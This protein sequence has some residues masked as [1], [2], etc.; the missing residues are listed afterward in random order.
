V[1]RLTISEREK[2][3]LEPGASE[4]R[5]LHL[6]SSGG[7]LGA[8][9][10]VLELA[11][12]SSTFGYEGIVGALKNMEDPTPEFITVAESRGLKTKIFECA[13]SFDIRAALNIKKFINNH[14]VKILHCHGYKEDVFGLVT[15]AGRISKI[16]TNHLWKT[17]TLKAKCYCLMDALIIRSYDRIVGVSDEIVQGMNNVGIR[18]AFKI[19]NGIDCARFN[20]KPV[21]AAFVK[22][23]NLQTSDF[24]L[25]MISSLSYEKNHQAVFKA[26]SGMDKPNLK[27]LIV[28]SGYLDKD[29]RKQ[30]E[31]MGLSERV[32]FT[33]TLSNVTDVLSV[34]KVFLLPSLSEGL[35]MALL[36]AMASGK[37]VVASNV[38]EVG[39]V[40]EHHV[41]GLLVERNNI[42]EL[43]SAI[44]FFFE[45]KEKISEYG[46]AARSR[47]VAKFSSKIMAQ[48]YCK[49][50][51]SMLSSVASMEK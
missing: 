6:R 34:V 29:L 35:P 42:D 26:I 49:I 12:E 47:V 37:A 20:I 9:N 27:L 3:L 51:D 40:V 48:N 23:Y 4:M 17:S 7:M 41:N 33:G 32:V 2:T 13:C 1:S 31:E 46:C 11:K 15:R 16:A 50:Y 21:D 44:E 43:R 38:G 28:G 39:N 5:V 24:V 45:N 18:N 22:K 30:V 14:Q 25:G 36:E 8:E 10:V 19:A